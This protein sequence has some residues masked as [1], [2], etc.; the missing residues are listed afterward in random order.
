M[1]MRV[2]TNISA[3]NAQRTLVQSQRSIGKSMEQ[4]ASGS[5]INKA[6]DDAAGLAI[7]EGMKSQ[8]RS[9]GQAQRN[10][11]DGISMV[12]TA[13]GGLNEVSNIL[14][15]MRELGI[16]AS[17]DTIGD[18]ERGFLNKEVQ[19]LKAESQRIT[20]TTRF[21]NAKLIDGSGDKFD[22]QVGIGND[23]EADRIT[24]NASE[25]NASIDNLGIAGFDFSS[26]AGAQDALEMIDKAQTQVNGFR[27]GLGALQNRL[28]STVDNLGVQN[29]N[30]SAANSRIRDTDVAAASAESARNTVLL[31]AN[32]SVLAQANQMPQAALKLIG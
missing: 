25:T 30:I 15:R 12:Q 7:S 10:A 17:S 24:Y 6:A 32:T 1:G 14:T 9:L 2:S 21:G 23:N 4:L 27:A 5:R 29:E 13:E 16:Q 26:K 28:T 31:Q 3:V 18:T 11:N 8:I 20:Q 22:F 19:Q